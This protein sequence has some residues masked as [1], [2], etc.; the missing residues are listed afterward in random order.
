[1]NGLT[2]AMCINATVLFA[3]L[4]ADLGPH[5]KV[6]PFRVVRPVLTGAAIVP[7][8]LKGFAGSGSG[9]VLELAATIAGLVLGL[10]ASSQTT[11]YRSPR[12]GR[13]ASRAGLGY[14]AVWF[15]VIGARAAFSYGSVHWFPHQLG[16]WMS[17]NQITADALTDALIFMALAMMLTRTASLAGRAARV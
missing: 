1:M 12:T 13:A 11:V 17:T 3:V 6:G 4:E 2:Q 10:L 5:R 16:R 7:L 14:A 15:V 8:F 9:L